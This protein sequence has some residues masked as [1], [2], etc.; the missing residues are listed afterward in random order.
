MRFK[1]SSEFSNCF[2][3]NTEQV[4]VKKPNEIVSF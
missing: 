4:I 2:H 1:Q 3:R